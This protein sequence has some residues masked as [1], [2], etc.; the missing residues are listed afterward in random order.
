VTWIEHDL[1]R[2]LP[3]PACAFDRVVCALVVDHIRDLRAFFGEL[4]RIV[5]GDG[6]IVVSV[7]HPAM[8]LKGTQARFHDPVTGETIYPESA[9]N[10]ISDY[11]LG[12]VRAGLAIEEMS[13]HV[14]D[15]ALA[16]AAPR[17]EKY[18]GWPMLLVMKLRPSRDARP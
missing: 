6:A 17:A 7:M 11:V 5:R 1:A 12:A 8:M 16:A 13:E 15:A 10:Q 3:V 18:L 14:V 4:G 2:P 9:P